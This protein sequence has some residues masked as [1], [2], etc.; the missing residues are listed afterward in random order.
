MNWDSMSWLIVLG[1]SLFVFFVLLFLLSRFVGSMKTE[2]NLEIASLKDTLIDPDNPVGLSGDEF[3]KLKQQQAEAQRNLGE[4]LSKFPIKKP[5][6]YRE[7][8]NLEGQR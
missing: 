7:S 4:V 2:Q 1:F 6:N 3:E 8:D 5:N